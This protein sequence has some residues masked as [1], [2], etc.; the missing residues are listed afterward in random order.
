MQ[1]GH[2]VCRVDHFELVISRSGDSTPKLRKVFPIYP[3]PTKYADTFCPVSIL[4]AYCKA[5]NKLCSVAD[6]DFLFPKMLSSFE[7]GTDRHILAIATPHA[8]IPAD[9]FQKK[10]K[11]HLE[12]EELRAVGVN[13]IEF[14]ADS[15][16]LG[17]RIV[18]KMKW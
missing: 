2:L 9:S 7:Q 17:G 15:L 18:F 3:T 5:R 12:S 14:T 6:N 8:C 1:V 11:S 16:K 10:F 4:S 13:P